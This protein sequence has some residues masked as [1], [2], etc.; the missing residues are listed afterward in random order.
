[1]KKF[2]K[3][4][5]QN[6]K[7]SR[8]FDIW[9]FDEMCCYLFFEVL[10]LKNKVF[11]SD[12]HILEIPFTVFIY[13]LT[14]FTIIKPFFT[15]FTYFTIHVHIFIFFAFLKIFTFHTMFTVSVI[16]VAWRFLYKTI[17]RFI[18]KSHAVNKFQRT[19][20]KK[21]LTVRFFFFKPFSKRK[22]DG[23]FNVFISTVKAK[24]FKFSAIFGNI[25]WLSYP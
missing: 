18:H 7:R 23:T 17:Y 20:P 16:K 2:S 6:L 5:L 4:L 22:K 10:T 9:Y 11:I 3:S 19:T 8:S 15:N 13:F 12:L 14:I 1:M 24:L 25:K 21:V